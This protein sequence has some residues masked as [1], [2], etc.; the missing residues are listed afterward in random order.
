[1]N[2]RRKWSRELKLKI[3]AQRNAGIA[4]A[5]L[6]RQYEVSVNQIYVWEKQLSKYGSKAFQGNGNAY[7]DEAYVAGLERKLAQTVMEVELLKKA[8]KLLENAC[9]VGNPS[10]GKS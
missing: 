3:L 9:Q 10:G 7:S 4:V 6:A 8:N 5:A 2:S 1:M